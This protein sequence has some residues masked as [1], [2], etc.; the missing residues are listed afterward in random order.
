MVLILLLTCYQP[1]LQGAQVFRS[2][3]DMPLWGAWVAQLVECLTLAQVMISWFVS[4]S[5]ASGFVL[6]AQSL[7][8]ASN[9]VS[10]ALSAPPLL[11]L[12]LS[13][14]LKNK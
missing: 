14:S 6:I 13:L 4:S 10:L 3:Q 8:P 2:H 11:T 1:F 12:C 7:E 9:S 5:P